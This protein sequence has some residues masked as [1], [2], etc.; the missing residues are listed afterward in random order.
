MEKVALLFGKGGIVRM[1]IQNPSFTAN[2]ANCHEW[3][4]IRVNSR[5]SRQRLAFTERLQDNKFDILNL[6][7]GHQG[8]RV[9]PRLTV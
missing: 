7:T 1:W 9:N 4:K 5:N 3:S 6:H 2:D 8:I